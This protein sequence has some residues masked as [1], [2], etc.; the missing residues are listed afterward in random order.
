LKKDLDSTVWG[1]LREKGWLRDMMKK[2]NPTESLSF[3]QAYQQGCMHRVDWGI[4]DPECIQ[5]FTN[6]LI[7]ESKLR[8]AGVKSD[9][10][11]L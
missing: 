10:S 1:T 11:R 4:I 6:K 9:H 7:R 8:L 3:L 5:R 2:R